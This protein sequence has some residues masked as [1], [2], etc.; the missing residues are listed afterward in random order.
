[1]VDACGFLDRS[2]DVKRI[3]VRLFFISR[4]RKVR[5]R[6]I[7]IDFFFFFSCIFESQFQCESKHRF[8]LKKAGKKRR[9]PLALRCEERKARSAENESR[10]RGYAALCVGGI[11]SL[12]QIRE[13]A[14]YQRDHAE[15]AKVH[16]VA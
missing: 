7:R 9:D 14:A 10:R 16:D 11:Q 3:A 8:L 2:C 15:I 5:H 12:S 6:S 1:M 4:K 13:Q